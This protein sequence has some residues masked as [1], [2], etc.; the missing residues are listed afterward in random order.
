VNQNSKKSGQNTTLFFVLKQMESSF[1]FYLVYFQPP[2]PIS[3][4]FMMAIIK[5]K[6]KYQPWYS[7]DE[8]LRIKRLQLIYSSFVPLILARFLSAEGKE[9]A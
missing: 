5:R 6:A 8:S 1:L 9:I 2:S 7:Q 3:S 4:S